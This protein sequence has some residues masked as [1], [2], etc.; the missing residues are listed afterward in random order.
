MRLLNSWVLFSATFGT[1]GIAV[2]QNPEPT[3]KQP[4]TTLNIS[5]VQ[6]SVKVGSPV[7]IRVILKNI[8]DHDIVVGR[9]VGGMD[10]RIDVRDAH[11]KLV[12]DTKLG[13]FRNGHVANLDL[14]RISPQ[15]LTGNAYYGTLRPGE[16]SKWELDASKLYDIKQPGSYS[17]Q[18]DRRDPEDLSTFVKSNTIT[19]KVTP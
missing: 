18:V 13:Y 4:V 15:D 12:A 3:Q 14:S 10:C 2:A 11:G 8:S 7:R 1:L 9:E 16:T 17:I 19:V 6:E 5:T